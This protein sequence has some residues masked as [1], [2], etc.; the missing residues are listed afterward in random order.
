MSEPVPADWD[1]QPV[2]V[3]VGENFNK[4][5]KDKK[6]NVVVEFCKSHLTY[7]DLGH[8]VS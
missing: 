3:L 4:V 7:L 5:A 1:A 6:K 2:K 8:P